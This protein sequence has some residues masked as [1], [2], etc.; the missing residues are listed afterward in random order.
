LKTLSNK[1]YYEFIFENYYDAILLA[2]PD[3]S[4]FRANP[5]ACEMFQRS[6]E[7]IIEIGRDG[8]EDKDNPYFKAALEERALNGKARAQFNG[9]RK[10]GSVFPVDYTTAVIKDENNE[11][12]II[13]FIR[14][15]SVYKKAEDNESI[16]A[17]QM[18]LYANYDYLTSIYNR[19]TFLDKLEL[20]IRKSK[21]FQVPTS[22]MMIDIDRFK[23]INDTYGH[24][25]G[26]IV[27]KRVSQILREGIRTKDILGRYGGDEFVICL[28]E[29]SFDES[30][31]IAERLRSKIECVTIKQGSF[32]INVTASFGIAAYDCG[33]NEDADSLISRADRNMYKAK[34]KR[35]NVYKFNL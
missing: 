9:V 33:V 24:L 14:D 30:V 29:T 35:N 13:N 34:M 15:M 12:W 16:I 3:G 32:E 2:R 11:I 31:N 26:D 23:Y 4:I 17:S 10:D 7:E 8:I 6:E 28:P 25:A 21:N 27:L 22:L 5:A 20:E 1:E 19:R 18:E